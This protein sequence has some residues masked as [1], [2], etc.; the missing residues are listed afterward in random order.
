MTDRSKHRSPSRVRYAKKHPSLTVHFDEET[1]ARV[2][3]LR[4]RTGLTLNQ[5]VRQAL[6]SL[7][8]HVDKIHEQGRRQGEAEGRRAGL[9]EGNQQGRV[10]ARSAWKLTYPCSGCGKPMAI[11]VGGPEAKRAI[12]TLIDQGWGHEECLE[13]SEAADR[14]D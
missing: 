4:A 2:L 5:L 3:A 11:R 6:G 8:T 13:S 9:E 10:A 14:G 12:E 1:Y 7:E